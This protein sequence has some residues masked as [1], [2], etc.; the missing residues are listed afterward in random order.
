MTTTDKLDEELLNEQGWA[1]VDWM[2]DTGSIM[3]GHAFN[4]IKPKLREIILAHRRA[5]QAAPAPSDALREAFIAGAMAVH[6]QWLHACE[7]GET[8][9]RGDP[10]FGEAADD[11]CAALSTPTEER[12]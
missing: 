5:S 7:Q 6:S 2:K 1:F 8:P 4:G 12:Q 3:S 11:Y 9:P 10:E